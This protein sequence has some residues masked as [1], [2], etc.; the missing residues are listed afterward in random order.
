M[1]TL[2][3]VD[4]EAVV[5]LKAVGACETAHTRL[6]AALA[7]FPVAAFCRDGS[8]WVTLAVPAAGSDVP[9]SLLLVS[10]GTKSDVNLHF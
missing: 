10:T 5:V 9:V 2:T 7:R 3:S 1:F 4:G 6:A 8:N